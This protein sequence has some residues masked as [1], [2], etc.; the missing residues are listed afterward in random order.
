MNF[1]E[2]KFSSTYTNLKCSMC[3]N[4]HS[5][6]SIYLRKNLDNCYNELVH[7]F[8]NVCLPIKFL[9]LVII[10]EFLIKIQLRAPLPPF[11]KYLS[12]RLKIECAIFFNKVNLSNKM[13]N[14]KSIMIIGRCGSLLI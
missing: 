7:L 8:F 10:C 3:F 13:K 4:F 6:F 2:N 1:S 11:F 12:V 14:R 9:T 5:K